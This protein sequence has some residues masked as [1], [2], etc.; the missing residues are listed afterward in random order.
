MWNVLNV[1]GSGLYRFHE[2]RGQ[3]S[4]LPAMMASSSSLFDA[5]AYC[6][7]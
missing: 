1:G 7:A 5:L 3:G 2:V 4:C 6:W